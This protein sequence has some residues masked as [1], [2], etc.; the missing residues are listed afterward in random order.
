MK[1]LQ[2]LG[3]YDPSRPGSTRPRE[4]EFMRFSLTYHTYR[5]WIPL[6]HP[7]RIEINLLADKDLEMVFAQKDMLKLDAYV[8]WC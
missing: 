7:E 4:D 3:K 6:K 8:H 1:R 5:R 2:E